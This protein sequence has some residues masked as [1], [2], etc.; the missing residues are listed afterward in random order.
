MYAFIF[1]HSLPYFGYVEVMT[2]SQLT[3]DLFHPPTIA[4]DYGGVR[5]CSF[6]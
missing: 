2:G 3:H 4:E 1:F 6:H 5:I